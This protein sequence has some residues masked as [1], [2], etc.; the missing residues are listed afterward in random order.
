[1]SRKKEVAK[2][3]KTKKTTKAKKEPE[4]KVWE[5]GDLVVQCKC[6]REQVVTKGVQH[7][8]QFTLTTREDSFIQLNCD[9]C[10]TEIKIGFREGE[11]PPQP[12][13]VEE[14]KPTED[15][16]IQETSKEEQSL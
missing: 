3:V 8:I 7:G 16:G 1:M 12:E 13:P 14:S 11:A 10:D 4:V 5:Y 6:G 15:E 2:V 9:S